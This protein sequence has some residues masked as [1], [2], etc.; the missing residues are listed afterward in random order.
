MKIGK[1][2]YN[3]QYNQLNRKRLDWQTEEEVRLGWL[4]E[5]QNVLGIIFHAERGR[6]DADYN[7]VII[8]FKNRGLFHGNTSSPKF[9]EALEEL[10]RYISAKSCAE[11]ISVQNYQGIAID[12]DSIAFAYIP[13]EGESI[14]HGPIM[15]LSHA[16]VKM[17]FEACYHSSRRALTAVNLIEDF[18]HGSIAGRKLMQALSD[19][20]M[21]YLDNPKNNKVKMLYMEWKALYGQVADLSSFQVDGILQTIGFSCST[22]AA[23]KLSRIL[24]VIHTFDSIIIK[25]LAA[26]IVSNFTELTAYSDFAQNAIA[27]KDENLINMI[28]QDIEHSQLYSRANIHGFVEE[29]LFSWYIDIC[30]TNDHPDIVNEIINSLKDVLIKLS[31]YQMKD[32]SH[33]QANDVLKRFYQNIVPQVLRKSL[34]EFYTPDWLVEVTLDKITGQYDELRFLDPT[35]GSASFLL[36]IIKRIRADSNLSSAQL[37]QRITQN[38]W[39]FDLNPLAVQTARVNY[40]IAISDLI[41]ETPGIDIE[42]PVLLA[43]AIYAPS[44]DEDG[45]TSVVNY[46]IGSSEAD[47]TISLPTELALSRDRLDA[48][49]S[50][51]GECVESN[52]DVV[53]ML[54]RLVSRCAISPS[55]CTAWEGILST[56]YERVLNLHR[57]NWNGIWFRIVRN[58]FWSA[59]AGDFD[60]IVGN[61]P[62]VRWSKLP[63]LYR[64]R[65]M[66]TCRRYDIFSHTPFYGGNELDISGLITYT[67]SDKW[68][69]NGGQLVFLLTQTHFQSASSEGFRR[70]C[71][72]GQNYLS[73]I[74][75]DDLKA[76]KPF[77]DAANKTVIFVARKGETQPVFPVDYIVWN[78][79]PGESR[80]IP[81]HAAKQD[82]LAR[83]MRHFNEANPVQ[84]GSSPWA[85]LPPGEFDT[86]R[87][88]VGR[89]TWTEGRKGITCDLNGVYFVNVINISH[90][91]SL[92]Q[93]ETRPE[94]GRTNIGPKRRFWIEPN[95][96]YPVIKGASDLKACYFDPKHELYA[97]VPNNGITAELLSQAETVMTNNNFRLYSYFRTYEQQLKNR[98][99][100]RTRMPSAPY[101]SVYNVG[102]YTFAPWKVV[103]PEQPGN[104]GLPVAVVNTRTLQGVGEKVIV[105]DHKI[106]FAEFEE[107]RKAFYLCGILSC[108][109]VQKY[110]ASFHIML[111]VGDIFKHMR[112]P[113]FE[114]TNAQHVHL[115]DLVQAAH[116]EQDL[117]R[118]KGL[119]TQISEIGNYIIENWIP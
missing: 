44:P 110:I 109:H 28:N 62:W 84:G 39:G 107:P 50:T 99:T 117:N 11:G 14:V 65:I 35:C 78:S 93:I 57:R 5:L 49:F 106:F 38:V 76:L 2:M 70:F 79:I 81:E 25:L 103:W 9:Q 16:S 3:E 48:V 1:D 36:A 88:L 75:V 15:P 89:C 63:E 96:L 10:S 104:N 73:P 100:Y 119:L 53:S 42:I 92:V 69:K 82:V 24:F 26:E 86:C 97:I 32:L 12:G 85:I 118:R 18:G 22:V 90:D 68:L 13:A 87:K 111:Q 115:I 33:A 64:N 23:D 116:N 60:V 6:S 94:A 95:L 67:V 19:A 77:T 113:E 114:P 30:I 108:S 58:Y 66:P 7:Q 91:G 105:P 31:F 55:E 4:T 46:V 17:V 83:T 27:V 47:L 52:M 101:Y 29:P 20:L 71:I 34:G 112:L 8:E 51:M 80:T 54:D 21:H 72:D 74:A 59:T 37:L 56:T 98:S 41:A 40:L 102:E 43:D 61:P 45:D